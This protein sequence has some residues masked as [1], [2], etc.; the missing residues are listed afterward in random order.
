MRNYSASSDN[1][2]FARRTGSNDDDIFLGTTGR[3]VYFA[4]GGNDNVLGDWGNDRLD[5]GAGNDGVYGGGGNDRLTGGP[6]N[7]YLGGEAGTD[8]IS[9]GG[10][11][12][13]FS[14]T[15]NGNFLFGGGGIDRITD[16]DPNGADD[17]LMIMLINYGFGIDSFADLKRGMRM[18]RGDTVM[19]FGNG[20]ILILEDVTIRELRADDFLIFGG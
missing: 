4:R 14:Y 3:D 16:F 8:L 12:D 10:G 20:D 17:D 18:S 1:F 13:T 7:D 5:G 6:G 19:N 11:K 9:G 2:L 15:A